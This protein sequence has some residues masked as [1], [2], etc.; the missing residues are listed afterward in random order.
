M[1]K[2]DM[3]DEVRAQLAVDLNCRPADFL[4]EGFTFAEAG[5]NPGRRPFPREASHFDMLTMG[6]GIVVSATPD[7][8][9][10]LRESLAGADAYTAFSM[11]FVYGQT[12]YFLPNLDSQPIL[13]APDGFDISLIEREEILPL[14]GT[15]GFRNAIQYDVNHPRPDVLAVVARQRGEVVGIAGA[16]ADCARLW[17]VGI[18][19]LPAYRKAGLAAALVS[20]L[21][22]EILERGYIPYYGTGSS[23]IASQRV[24]YRAGYQI[25]WMCA[26]RGRFGEMMTGSCG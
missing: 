16:S 22:R 26:F 8:L 18:D 12:L 3:L 9:P 2:Q 17:Q 1:T 25:A 14:Y 19:V 20:L 5:D 13:P 24:A 11:P 21:T 10:G 7:L 6:S 15:E 4:A 23:N